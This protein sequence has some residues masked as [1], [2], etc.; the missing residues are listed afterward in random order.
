MKSRVTGTSGSDDPTRATLVFLHAK[1]AKDAGHDVS[2]ALLGDRT[3]R[4]RV[5]RSRT[6]DGHNPASKILPKTG[7]SDQRRLGG[8]VGPF[9]AVALR[10]VHKAVSPPSTAHHS[11]YLP[12]ATYLPGNSSCFFRNSIMY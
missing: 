5:T 11:K 3:T 8:V 10:K 1:G 7:R 12:A 4:T 6:E 9:A 2:I